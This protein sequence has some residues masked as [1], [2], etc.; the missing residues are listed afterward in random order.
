MKG[1][2]ELIIQEKVGIVNG[3]EV[4]SKTK[5]GHSGKSKVN[6]AMECAHINNFRGRV[7]MD[8]YKV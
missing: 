4:Q 6:Y 7:L 1:K 5:N 8:D 3:L 2:E